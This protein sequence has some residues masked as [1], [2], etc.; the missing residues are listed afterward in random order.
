MTESSMSKRAS[1]RQPP[2][3]VVI[4]GVQPEIDGGRFP[5]KRV[6]G[7]RIMVEADVFADGHDVI[8][9]RLLYR[10]E[11]EAD[12]QEQPM[13]ALGNDRWRAEFTVGT[14]GRY[15]YTV[16]GWVDPFLTWR[17]GITLRI[18]A[19]QDVST[20]LEIGSYVVEE[21]ASRATA[22]EAALLRAWA[23]AMRS[24]TDPVARDAVALD[25]ALAGI[26]TRFPDRSAA[27]RYGLE[28]G[29]VVDPPKARFS[30]W[31]ELFPRSWAGEPGRHGTFID[32]LARLPYVADMGFDVLY[33]PP[34][35]PIGRTFR[36]GPNNTMH[37]R[38]GDVGSPW[39][40]GSD[41]GG[42]MSIEPK[43]GTIDDFRRLVAAARALGIDVALDIAF[44]CSPD[45]PYVRQHPEWFRHRPDGTIQYAE[46]PPKKYQDIYPFDFECAAWQELWT[47]LERVFAYWIAQGVRIFRVDNPHTKAFAFWEWV[48]GRLKARHPEVIFL[49][50]AFTRPR[51]MYRLAK[52]GFSQSYTYFTWRNTR[53]E[54]TAYFEE[55]ETS[56]VREYFRPNLW[57]NTPDI[58][59]AY[60][61]RGGRPAFLVRA[62]LAATL[63]ASY[64]IYGPAFELGE[65]APREP[66]SEEYLDSEKY[67]I[68]QRDLDVAHSLRPF[69]TRLNRIR[70][71]HPALQTD[72]GIRFHVTDNPE[73]L[74]YS[75]TTSTRSN[76]LIVVVNLDP[77]YEQSGWVTLDLAALGL[78]DAGAFELSDLLIDQRFMWYGARNFVRLTPAL[79]PAHLFH[80]QAVL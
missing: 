2:S 73:L 6:A 16:E 51:L 15:R 21:I 17:H 45:H 29:V 20:E 47:E 80:V 46:N 5:I 10:R 53:D 59:H 66:D 63:G 35:H 32:V 72:E 50:E 76:V 24:A 31:Y 36:K 75:R 26:A 77:V 56:G 69:L 55:F 12:W 43:L 13:T 62:L 30:S 44:Q 40:I 38:A 25:S 48:I 60:L 1:T 3:R 7:D 8:A 34:I 22:P 41:A 11:E 67:E 4:E 70:R 33:L 37:A 54:L 65:N 68:K 27:C 71:D 9:C 74:C 14:I 19:G 61:Q 64:G 49:S 58:L 28:L 42:H 18:R 52:L 57:P 78:A 39:A 23:G 79:A